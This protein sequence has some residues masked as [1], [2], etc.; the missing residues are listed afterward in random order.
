MSRNTWGKLGREYYSWYV[1]DMDA[2]EKFIIIRNI[3]VDY[4]DKSL[5]YT[6]T[7]KYQVHR[8]TD[9]PN[10]SCFAMVIDLFE[11]IHGSRHWSRGQHHYIWIDRARIV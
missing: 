7:L 4:R 9:Y 10:R 5:G 1:E 8:F 6:S 3:D 11:P 2:L